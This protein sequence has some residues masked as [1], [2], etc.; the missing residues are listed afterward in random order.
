MLTHECINSELTEP[1]TQDRQSQNM[2]LI[3]LPDKI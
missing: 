2:V 3:E 1:L